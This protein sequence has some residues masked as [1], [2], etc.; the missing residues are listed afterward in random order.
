[1]S[2]PTQILPANP[3]GPQCACAEPVLWRGHPPR[4]LWMLRLHD[5]FLIPISLLWT[6]F[7]GAV[8]ASW[9][10]QS[11][12][13]GFENFAGIIL[14]GI[15]LAGI[16]LLFGRFVLDWIRRRH[17]WYVLTSRRVLIRQNW[18]IERVQS[19]RRDQLLDMLLDEGFDNVGTIRF[20]GDNDAMPDLMMGYIPSTWFLPVAPPRFERIHHARDVFDLIRSTLH[21]RIRGQFP[22]ATPG[23]PPPIYRKGFHAHSAA[24]SASA[25]IRRTNS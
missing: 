11:P 8:T 24:L 7:I 3:A 2:E 4:G 10:L 18:P 21:V 16:Y 5:C 19:F 6:A 13:Q 14:I 17:T 20:I 12:H 23:D 1:M 15:L 22:K 25:V 9:L